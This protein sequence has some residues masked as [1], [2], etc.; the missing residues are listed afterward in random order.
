MEFTLPEPRRPAVYERAKLYDEVWNDPV[1]HVAQRYGISGVA[2]AKICRRLRVPLPGRG[3]WA[4]KS[5]GHEVPRTKLPPL[6][7]GEASSVKSYYR[8]PEQVPAPPLTVTEAD[9][10]A[11]EST[12]DAKIVVSPSLHDLHPLVAKTAAALAKAKPGDGVGSNVLAQARWT[13]SSRERWS[14]VR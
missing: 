8:R 7:K 3:Y 1:T 13:S 5:A 14:T 2:L 10:V 12:E 9:A 6:K 4:K 11:R